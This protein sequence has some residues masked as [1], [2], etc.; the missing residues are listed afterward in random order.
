[1]GLHIFNIHVN[2]VMLDFFF[3]SFFLCKVYMVKSVNAK[4]Y[5]TNIDNLPWG[6]NGHV[7]GSK[8]LYET[9]HG[10]IEG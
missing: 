8:R 1:M 10:L 3:F 4:Q 9:F 6:R 7:D 2:G 5:E